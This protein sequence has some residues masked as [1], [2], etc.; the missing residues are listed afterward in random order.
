MKWSSECVFFCC[1]R[2]CS[3]CNGSQLQG[4]FRWGAASNGSTVSFCCLCDTCQANLRRCSLH[5]AALSSSL[6]VHLCGL[7]TF[8]R[9]NLAAIKSYSMKGER[10]RGTLLNQGGNVSRCCIKLACARF[11]RALPHPTLLFACCP[12]PLSPAG[13]SWAV[14][15]PLMGSERNYRC[16]NNERLQ[17]QKKKM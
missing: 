11:K 1:N 12:A 8:A 14:C 5:T 4:L 9:S 2:W 3:L 6:N 7:N 17:E 16:Y 10:G 15:D 13:A